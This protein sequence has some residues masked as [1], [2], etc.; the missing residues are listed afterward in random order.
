MI[1]ASG[2]PQEAWKVFESHYAV[3][4]EHEREKEEDE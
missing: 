3:K 1:F 4:S 2:S